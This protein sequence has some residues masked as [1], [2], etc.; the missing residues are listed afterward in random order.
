MGTRVGLPKEMGLGSLS[1][2][3]RHNDSRVFGWGEATERH[4]LII[5]QTWVPGHLSALCSACDLV[6][7]LTRSLCEVWLV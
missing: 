4:D 3:L 1:T 5:D 2:F 6:K 7:A